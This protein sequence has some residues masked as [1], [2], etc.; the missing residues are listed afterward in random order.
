MN[1]KQSQAASLVSRRDVLKLGATGLARIGLTGCRLESTIEPR[2]FSATDLRPSSD[3]WEAV[4]ASFGVLD[5]LSY[6]NNAS[7][8]MPPDVV[9]Q[10]VADGYR[11]QSEDPIGFD[12]SSRLIQSP[13]RAHQ[14]RKSRTAL[15][16]K[17]PLAWP[18]QD[19]SR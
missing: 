13:R 2:T 5:G 12:N 10:A 16:H 18:N 19:T 11:A 1:H 3:Q 8:G 17:Y 15:C 7:I 14:V 9:A 4:L 6:M